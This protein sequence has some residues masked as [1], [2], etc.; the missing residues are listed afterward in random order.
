MPPWSAHLP[1]RGSGSPER[2]R[3]MA[4]LCGLRSAANEWRTRNSARVA[5]SS[6]WSWA[7]RSVAAGTKALCAFGAIWS[8]C[9]HNVPGPLSAKQQRRL[10]QGGG[11]HNS[12]LPCNRPASTALGNAWPAPTCASQPPGPELDQILH[13]AEP[14]GPLR[15]PLR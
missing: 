9:E 2:L 7:R 11:G 5:R 1:A 3:L 12:L 10:E 8:A 6:S 13:M 14:A 4:P 15:L